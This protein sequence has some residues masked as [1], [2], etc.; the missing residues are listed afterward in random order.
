MYMNCM[1]GILFVKFKMPYLNLDGDFVLFFSFFHFF[2]KWEGKKYFFHIGKNT[3]Y[4][5]VISIH[6]KN[7]P[8]L[9]KS[10]CVISILFK[11]GNLNFN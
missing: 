3:F 8:I 4:A 10:N 9:S 1:K 5:M 7:M 11:I 2:P 6:G